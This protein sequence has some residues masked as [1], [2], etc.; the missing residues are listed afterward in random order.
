MSLTGRAGQVLGTAGGDLHDAVAAGVANPR[1]AALSVW[2]E[3]TLI[4][5]YANP[6]ALA[7]EIISA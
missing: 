7:R 6:P 2:D 4:A 5:G 1:R 3:V